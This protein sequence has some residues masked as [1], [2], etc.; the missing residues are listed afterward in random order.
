MGN[1]SQALSVL[2]RSHL[3]GREAI[4]SHLVI[5]T[6]R[7]KVLECKTPGEQCWQKNRQVDFLVKTM[8]K[9]AP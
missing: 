8:N 5:L 7:N 9:Q 4:L 3:R 6:C 1:G 2:D